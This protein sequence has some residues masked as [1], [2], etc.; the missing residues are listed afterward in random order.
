MISR[1]SR[2]SAIENSRP[3]SRERFRIVEEGQ[4]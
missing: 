3:V 4:E 1:V 2:P